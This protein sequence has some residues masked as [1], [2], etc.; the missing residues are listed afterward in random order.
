MK[1]ELTEEQVKKF[2]EWKSTHEAVSE[3]AIGGRYAF[4]FSPTGVGVFVFIT[5]NSNGEKLDLNDYDS[6]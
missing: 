5:D 4:T 2:E 6:F 1:F 3:G